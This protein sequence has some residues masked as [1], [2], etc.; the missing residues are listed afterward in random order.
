M[1]VKG[2]KTNGLKQ[3]ADATPTDDIQPT[4]DVTPPTDDIQ[5]TSDVTPPIDDIQLTSDV[6]PPIDNIQL[7]SD[8]TPIDDG[9]EKLNKQPK[10]L[11]RLV[12]VTGDKGG[13]GK[14]VVARILLDIYRNRNVKCIAYE[15]DQSN[16]QLYRHYNKVLPGVQTLKLNQR[17]G[18][19]ALQ[20]DLKGLSP[21]ISLVDLPAGAAESFENVAKDI[22]LFKNTQRLGYRITMVSVLSRVKE[23]LE[24]LKRL[25]DFC[26]DRVDYVIVKNLY[27]G[28]EHK[29]TR[30]NNSEIRQTLA[31]LGAVELLLP[32]LF[33]EIFDLIDVN[34]L[35]FREALEHDAFSFSNQS[36]VFGWIETCEAEFARAGALLGID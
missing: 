29:F 17:G 30:Y 25:V 15:C 20:D 16:P 18:A 1:A 21:K 12:L 31:G 8:I 19:D 7:T 35:T 32:E 34:D 13:T 6:T 33:D 24:Q 36:R 28:D 4:S 5:L 10:F 26:G 3:A 22:F 27:W 9:T 2:K 14:S 11:G 23:S